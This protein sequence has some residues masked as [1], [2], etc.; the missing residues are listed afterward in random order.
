ML[1]WFLTYGKELLCKLVNT[2]LVT[3]IYVVSV[4]HCQC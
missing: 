2:E 4:K 1:K 3:A